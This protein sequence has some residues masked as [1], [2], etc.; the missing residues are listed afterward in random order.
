MQKADSLS[1]SC[2]RLRATRGA[3]LSPLLEFTSTLQPQAGRERIVSSQHSTANVN[4]TH[5]AIYRRAKICQKHRACERQLPSSW[6]NIPRT[7]FAASPLPTKKYDQLTHHILRAGRDSD[8]PSPTLPNLARA[9][10]PCQAGPGPGPRPVQ[11]GGAACSTLR[12]QLVTCVP[13]P[14]RSRRARAQFAACRGAV[15]AVTRRV[16]EAAA[17][18]QARPQH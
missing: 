18:W 10:R 9:G 8:V 17:A 3:S 13:T 4:D 14:G 1:R 15:P 7:K 6:W 5:H 11:V 12:L 2:W 16:S